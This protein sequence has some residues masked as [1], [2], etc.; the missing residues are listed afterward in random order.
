MKKQLLPLLVLFSLSISAQEQYTG[1]GLSSRVGV[2][3][4][5]FNPAELH[6]QSN[7]FD[8]H[9]IGFN[10]RVSNNILGVDDIINNDNLENILFRGT[11]PVNLRANV[12]AMGLGMSVKFK[13]WTLGISSTFHGNLDIIDVDPRLGDA[14]VNAG[15]NALV[16]GSA[17]VANNYNQRVNGTTWGE[18]GATAA[19]SLV[20]KAKHKLNVGITGKLLFPGSYANLGMDRFNGTISRVG[21][22]ALLT[23]TQ[24]SVNFAYSGTLANSFTQ[25][26]NYRESAFGGLNG[27]GADIGI[28]YQLRDTPP[29]NPKKNQN[30]YKLNLGLAIRNLGAMTFNDNNNQSTN[31]TLSIQGTQSLNLNQFENVESLREIETILLNSGYLTRTDGTRDFR[32]QL[33][34]TLALYG[35][36]KIIP[37][38]FV[39]AYLLQRLNN[40]EVNDQI[41][42]QNTF[43]VTPHVDLGFFEIFVPFTQNEISGFNTGLAFRAGGFFVGSSSGVTALMTNPKQA[44]LYMGW[45]IGIF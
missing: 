4:A 34:T 5:Q 39:S 16:G 22:I 31:Y 33:P 36:V 7:K 2:L 11:D 19:F 30:R 37:K 45:R 20:N 1:I 21:G 10:A 14:F 43:I 13:R 29:E 9:L 32:V 44:D 41:A 17:T 24:A 27:V 15:I 6:N 18:L 40:V 38:L 42:A 35:D 23:N 12:Q 26:D 28:N 3:N 8:I 25:F